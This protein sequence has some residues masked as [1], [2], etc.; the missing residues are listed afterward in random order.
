MLYGID[1]SKWN[2]DI[3]WDKVNA[4]FAIVRAGHG[5]N[6]IDPKAHFN[7]LRCNQRNIPVGLYW[8]SYAMSPDMAKKEAGYAVAFAKQHVIKLPIWFDFEYDSV[9]YANKNC[10]HIATSDFH[11]I[12]K[13]FCNEVERLGYYTGFYVNNDFYTRYNCK[14]LKDRYDMWLADYSKPRDTKIANMRQYTSSGECPG[15]MG[16]VDLDVSFYNY[17]EIILNAGL[18]NLQNN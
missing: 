11:A 13:A 1:V 8:F 18:N 7:C 14:S 2:G 3:N 15:I 17:P 9:S 10:V 12:T 6:N 5:K 16:K 4:D